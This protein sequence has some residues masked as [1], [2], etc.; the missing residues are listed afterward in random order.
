MRL[1]HNGGTI[2]AARYICGAHLPLEVDHV[3]GRWLSHVLRDPVLL[4][5]RTF[6]HGEE[7]RVG[8]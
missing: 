1:V 3:V 2:V 8:A 6:F 5:D 7:F 4:R